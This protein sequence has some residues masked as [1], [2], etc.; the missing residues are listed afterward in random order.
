M[1]SDHTF[2][3]SCKTKRQQQISKIPKKKGCYMFQKQ[4]TTII[5]ENI[6]ASEV[7]DEVDWIESESN[8]MKNEVN[9]KW[10]EGELREFKGI[11]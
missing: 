10:T 8:W 6:E 1:K 7:E 5:D 3:I 2:M 9:E 11:E 4:N